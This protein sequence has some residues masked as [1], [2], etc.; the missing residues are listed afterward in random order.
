MPVPTS[1]TDLSVTPASNSPPSTDTLSN[2]DD[3]LRAQA[4]IIKRVATGVDPQTPDINGGTIDGTTQASGTINGPIAVGGT[5]TAA[6][7]LTLPAHVLGG[8]V[9]STGNPSLN[10]G[11]GALSAGS[12][13]FSSEVAITANPSGAKVLKLI[14]RSGTNDSVIQFFRSDGTTSEGFW[15]AQANGIDWYGT[16]GSKVLA[17]TDTGLAVTGLASTTG[18]LCIAAGQKIYLD[19][20]SGTGNTFIQEVNADEIGFY[21]GAALGLKVLATGAQ[22]TGVLSTSAN[23]GDWMVKHDN[24]NSSTPYGARIYYTAASPNNTSSTF[25]QCVDNAAARAEIRS[26]GGLANFSA[27]NVNL[28]DERTKT[29]I[30]DAGNYL[31]KICAIPVRT[32]KY[33]DQTDELLN[34]GVIAQEV[35]VIAPEL[36]DVSGFGETP[37]DGVP[38]KAIYQTDLQYA[39]MKCIQ[40]LSAKNTA[41]EARLAAAGIA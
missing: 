1:I 36:V 23:I 16:T 28:S 10:L 12:G 17:I 29:A 6:A 20:V 7:A 34:L 2:A 18:S 38:L 4:S 21:A 11:T 27:N 30:V 25:I 22:V 39:L 40:E 41:L 32:F 9:T 15:N 5:W 3:Y 35:E 13:A 14:G 8:N 31:D 33:K 26:N 37:E 19:G 24:S